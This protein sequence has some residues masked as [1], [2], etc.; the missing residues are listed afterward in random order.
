MGFQCSHIRLP[1]GFG[2]SVGD[3]EL[4]GK[5]LKWNF[6]NPFSNKYCFRMNVTVWSFTG[7]FASNFICDNLLN[8]KII[9]SGVFCF[10]W[11]FSYVASLFT[12]L[13]SYIVCVPSNCTATQW[14]NITLSRHSCQLLLSKPLILSMSLSL[15]L[16][17]RE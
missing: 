12:S 17:V 13:K 5:N 2:S 9:F 8:M 14:L 15:F 1:L 10:D 16:L 11:Y 6:H 4:G 3:W 7:I